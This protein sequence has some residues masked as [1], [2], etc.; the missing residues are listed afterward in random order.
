[1]K[2]ER[3]G[4]GNRSEIILK[5]L[6]A[7]YYFNTRNGC[8]TGSGY[9][10]MPKVFIAPWNSANWV[11]IIRVNNE[12][13]EFGP[14]HMRS[15]F[16][17]EVNR[18]HFLVEWK[19]L[20]GI[21]ADFRVRVK[22][23]LKAG[24]LTGRLLYDGLNGKAQVEKIIFPI[25][26]FGYRPKCALAIP[27]GLGMLIRDAER[28]VFNNPDI[29]RKICWE[30]L[31]QASMQ[32]AAYVSDGQGMY[33][34]SRDAEGY[35]KHAE[36]R[37]TTRGTFIYS[38]IH[39]VPLSKA[40][41]TAYNLP[42]SVGYRIFRGGWYEAARIYRAWALQQRWATRGPRQRAG[43]TAAKITALAGWVWNRG[44]ISETVRPV[45]KLSKKVR[46]PL[47][48]DWY[49]WHRGQY[50]AEYPRYLPPR[51]GIK[52]FKT[53]IAGLKKRG[54]YCQ[55]YINGLCWD[56]DDIIWKQ[57][58]R[59][60]AVMNHDQTPKAYVFNHYLG[61]R[62]AYM[63]GSARPFR[64]KIIKI[65][66]QLNRTGIDGLYLDVIGNYTNSICY[67]SCHN[68]SPGGGK[69]QVEGYRTLLRQ[70]R[71]F[72]PGMTLCSESCA[73]VYMD[74]LEAGIM[75]DASWERFRDDTFKEAIPLFN[76]VYHGY[77][78][79]FGNYAM[80]DCIPP[81]DPLWPIKGK[82]KKEKDWQNKCPDQFCLEIAR[83]L[84]W[85]LQPTV[86]NLRLEHMNGEKFKGECEFLCQAIKIYYKHRDFL[87][88]GD[89]LPP[90]G[91]EVKNITVKFLLRNVFTPE[92]QHKLHSKKIPAILHSAWQASDGRRLLILSNY[93]REKTGFVYQQESQKINGTMQARSFMT[94]ELASAAS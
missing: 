28:N 90:G 74:L 38:A 82:W 24:L 94:M 85:G 20:G 35:I 16:P 6:D 8:L 59:Q 46:L 79:L 13:M 36:F 12:V 50:D 27:M 45:E 47:A 77:F 86:A 7:T 91:L 32:F 42:Y 48:L 5:G 33:F 73:E 10:D 30:Y 70:L 17:M 76:A 62:L 68:H 1:M 54:I 88:N 63:C 21:S 43:D 67:N 55:P 75:L 56:M 4:N 34:D 23:E 25:F 89:M 64:Q 84:I 40:A 19:G 60:S 58:G 11:L 51:E 83:G 37:G 71:R 53:A 2:L 39:Y 31:C 61:H 78:T 92:G 66:K 9:N 93:S 22:W 26:E 18:S 57:G 87:L 81:Y 52:R 3:R 41:A 44:K 65:A 49:W 72:C 80:L 14:E 15:F 29:N 69:Y